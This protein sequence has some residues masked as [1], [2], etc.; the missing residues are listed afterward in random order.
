MDAQ[1]ERKKK[2]K[3][4]RAVQDKLE[5]TKMIP[6]TKMKAPRNPQKKTYVVSIYWVCGFPRHREDAMVESVFSM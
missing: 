1:Q 3:K 5:V 4:K 2:R 6:S